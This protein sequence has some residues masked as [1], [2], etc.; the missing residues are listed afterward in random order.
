MTVNVNETE[1]KYD[2]PAGAGLPRLDGL[3][4]VAATSGPEQQR[5]DA[6]YY[7]TDDLRLLR[8]GITL[9]QRSGGNDSGWHLKLPLGH[10]TRREIR[11][12]R[13]G[14]ARTVPTELACLV[15]ARTR[16][17]PLRP[18]AQVTTIRQRLP[19]V[20]EAGRTPAR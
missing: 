14:K 11:R 9:R 1:A 6:E 4:Q 16:G 13:R 17:A 20:Q 10:G 15:R 12:P 7:D 18:V 19:R 5:L 2:A 3:P 8:A